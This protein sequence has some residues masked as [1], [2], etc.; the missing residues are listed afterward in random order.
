M[1]RLL[2]AVLM[3]GCSLE[4]ERCFNDPR[5]VGETALGCSLDDGNVASTIHVLLMKRL[6]GAVLM[7]GTLL[8]RSTCC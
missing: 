8:Q 5:A 2:G 6:L 4:R 1:K 3:T 7:T